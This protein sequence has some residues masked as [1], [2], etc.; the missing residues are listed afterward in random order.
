M[1][2]VVCVYNSEKT[3]ENVLLSGLKD[4][5]VEFELITLDNRNHRF[6][7][8]AEALNYGGNQ[9]KGDFIMFAH[10]DMF[11]EDKTW[12]ED[13]EKVLKDI[14]DLGVAGVAGAS[15]V[16]SSWVDRCRHS[17]TVMDENW[18]IPS[19][20][21]IAE[22]QTLDECVLIVS[23]QLFS[24]LKFDDNVF[25]GW[26]CYG[27]DYC[28]AAKSLG[29]KSYVIPGNS[30]HCCLRQNSRPWEFKNLFK[31]QKRLYKK[32]SGEHKTIFAWMGKL[33]WLTLRLREVLQLIGP[34]Y[35]KIFPG[36][37]TLLEKELSDCESVLDLGC[38]H[39]SPIYTV[40]IPYSVGV[41]H[42]DLFL[43]ESKR[44]GVHDDYIAAD[45]R[46]VE[47]EAN[48]FDAVVALDVLEKLSK[49][50]GVELIEKM[51]SWAKKKVLIR[52]TNIPAEENRDANQC[53]T[54]N[55][56]VWN[57]AEFE[58]QGFKVLGVGGWKKIKQEYTYIHTIL[59]AL[60]Q[61][62]VLHYPQQ[63][64]SLLVSRQP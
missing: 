57:K 51:Q 13:A 4:Q 15:E 64:V 61:K 55:N 24:E 21:E 22:V 35:I 47:F 20:K 49:Q 25:D 54:Q 31:Y 14:P 29:K 38:G 46:S 27:P 17:I 48:S 26:D 1:I 6:K 12:L 59:S 32:Y 56:S 58:G 41:E 50:E 42:S 9:A 37:D 16:G 52:T 11:F 63:A 33:N 62:I 3:L 18:V 36:Y 40:G 8:A 34:I 43:Q 7:S 39:H 5:S 19:V 60:T 28:L 44:L 2:S 45:I 30:N 53:L 10:Q 23:R